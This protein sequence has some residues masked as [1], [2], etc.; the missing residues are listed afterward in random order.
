MTFYPLHTTHH[1]P[2][3]TTM[4]E[5]NV[6]LPEETPLCSVWDDPKIVHIHADNGTKRWKCSYCGNDYSGW[7][8]TKALAHVGFQKYK[9]IAFCTYC[10]KEKET[11]RFAELIKGKNNKCDAA[12]VARETHD[13]NILQHNILMAS[14]LDTHQKKNKSLSVIDMLNAV[15]DALLSELTQ[16]TIGTSVT[17]SVGG[18]QTTLSTSLFFIQPSAESQMTMAIVDLIHSH[19]LPFTL[20]KEPKFL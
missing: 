5:S 1:T 16:S 19:A 17:T 6:Q 2:H 7:S 18:V 11:K 3:T 8:A 4:N 15:K 14:T 20:T 9:D 13:T 10:F 12:A